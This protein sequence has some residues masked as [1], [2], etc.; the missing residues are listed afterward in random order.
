MN[1]TLYQADRLLLP[2]FRI[3]AGVDEAGRG[4]L[5]GP[6]VTAAVVLDYS[7]PLSGMNDSKILSVKQRENLFD[8][9]TRSALSYSIAIIDPAM[10]DTLNILQATLVGMRHALE[11]LSIAP[12]LV[13]IDGNICPAG[14][15]GLSWAIIK[16]D[17]I[18]ACV[19]AASIVAKVTRDR[20]MLDLHAMYPDYGFD[21]HKGYPTQEHLAALRKYGVSPIHRRSFKPV[22]DM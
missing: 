8:S 22:C 3:L 16:G 1:D 6:V 15:K 7:Q 18:H 17:A 12:D 4:P 21:K 2:R 5:A 13:L 19:A 11:G 9:I 10:I 20:L 14:L